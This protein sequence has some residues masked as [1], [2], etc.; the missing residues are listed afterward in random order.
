MY[1]VRSNDVPDAEL[2]AAFAPFTNGPLS[3]PIDATGTAHRLV[4]AS[5]FLFVGRSR[6][7][8]YW[9][10]HRVTRNYLQ[11]ENGLA[12]VVIGR[13]GEPLTG[14]FYGAAP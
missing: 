14:G 9:L 13:P 10:K 3:L 11:V 4:D 1:A 12:I 2:A 7:G 5:E 6:N 8:V